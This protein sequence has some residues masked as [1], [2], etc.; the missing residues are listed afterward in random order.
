MRETDLFLWSWY[1]DNGLEADWKVMGRVPFNAARSNITEHACEDG[2]AVGHRI[3]R[4]R[5]GK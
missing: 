3:V 4:V 5:L 1:G 2:I